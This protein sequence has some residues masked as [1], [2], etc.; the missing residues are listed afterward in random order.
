MVTFLWIEKEKKQS[1]AVLLQIWQNV[2]T[3]L[4]FVF[5]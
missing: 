4:F 3:I 2:L 1:S 5:I